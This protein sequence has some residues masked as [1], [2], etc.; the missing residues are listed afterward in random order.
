MPYQ[1]RAA[2]RRCSFCGQRLG[3]VLVDGPDGVWICE[4]CTRFC[5]DIVEEHA[6]R[7]RAD[8]NPDTSTAPEQVDAE[9]A[10]RMLRQAPTATRPEGKP[11]CSFCGKDADATGKL[12]AGPDVYICAGCVRLCACVISPK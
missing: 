10:K 6:A 1:K 7:S 2:T 3:R 5:L 9:T 12:I 8:R 11:A 4:E